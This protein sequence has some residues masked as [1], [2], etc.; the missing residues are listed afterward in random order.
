MFG[1]NLKYSLATLAVA[2]SLLATAGPASAGTHG[3][4]A[5]QHNQSDLEFLAFGARA[6]SDGLGAGL[7]P[8]ADMG[9]QY[10]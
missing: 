7:I 2:G 3:A 5:Y 9:G 6:T 1:T 10:Y 4:A 8:M